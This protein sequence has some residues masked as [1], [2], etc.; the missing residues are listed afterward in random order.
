MKQ[1]KLDILKE[2]NKK[3]IGYREISFYEVAKKLGYNHIARQDVRDIEIAFLRENPTYK[4]FRFVKNP[5]KI[6]P[7]ES[8]FQTLVLSECEYETEG[9]CDYE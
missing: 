8:L 2:L 5:R 4:A 6:N 1:W 3:A 9:E 7:T